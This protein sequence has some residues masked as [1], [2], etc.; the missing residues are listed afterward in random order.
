MTQLTRKQRDFQARESLILDV[1][2]EL[3]EQF[4]YFGLSMDRIAQAVEYS[5][6]TIYQHFQSKEEVLCALC[7]RSMRVQQQMFQKATQFVG[8]PREKMCAILVAHQLYTH[9]YAREFN[10]VQMIKTASI[11]QK[12]PESS[13]Q[14]LAEIE[15]QCLQRIVNIVAEAIEC[16]DLVLEDMTPQELIFGLW[17]IAQGSSVIML[18]DTP[19]EEMGI[20]QPDLVIRAHCMR[21]LDVYGWQPLSH[22]WD[23]EQTY[24]RIE[25]ELF[26]EEL[27][28]FTSG[29]QHD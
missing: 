29:D 22:Q 24:H 26:I 25:T 15:D 12:I 4:G 14:A 18:S 19:L 5:K 8:H 21:L 17:S 1:S 13:Q 9:L 6:G 10:H 20:E 27:S 23:Y 11:R 28:R 7:A 3:F 16:Q 2:A